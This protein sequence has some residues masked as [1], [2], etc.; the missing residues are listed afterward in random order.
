MSDS[1]VRPPAGAHPPRAGGIGPGAG[2][3]WVGRKANQ[4]TNSSFD[5]IPSLTA[6]ERG[7]HLSTAGGPLSPTCPQGSAQVWPGWVLHW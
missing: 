7:S 5:A 3:E 1:N 4:I 6:G 2:V